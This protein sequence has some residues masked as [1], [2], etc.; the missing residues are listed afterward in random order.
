MPY[1][2]SATIFWLGLI[3]LLQHHVDEH[4]AINHVILRGPQLLAPVLNVREFDVT[5]DEDG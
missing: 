1:P 5:L 4:E 3:E 2:M